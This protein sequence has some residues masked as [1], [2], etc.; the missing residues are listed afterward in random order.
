MSD[1]PISVLLRLSRRFS[2]VLDPSFVST[3]SAVYL[4]VFATIYLGVAKWKLSNSIII[5]AC[6]S[7][8]PFIWVRFPP[9]VIW[10]S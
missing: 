7:W 1:A 6:I 2:R 3:S 4:T 5:S 10:L 8:E 9:S